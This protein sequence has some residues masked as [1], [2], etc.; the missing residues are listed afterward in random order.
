MSNEH[1]WDR[2]VSLVDKMGREVP[3]AMQQLWLGGRILPVGASLV[4]RHVFQIESNKPAEV[5]YAFMLPRDAAMRRFTV[6]GKNFS[7]TS[8]LKKTKEAVQSYEAGI[9]KGNLS[10]LV[11]QYR[12]G[13]VNLS[14]GNLRPRETVTV[15]L[16]LVAGVET[17]DDGFR[18]RFPFTLAPSYHPRARGVESRPG[19]G[20]LVV[21]GEEFG[22]VMLPEWRFDSKNLHEIGFD[23]ELWSPSGVN[24]VASPSHSIRITTAP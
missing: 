13:V 24:E 5:V 3:L 23:L 17:R 11:R 6:T 9:Q 15:L 20:E 21:P 12:D 18:F 16:E 4:V 7:I 19:K 22:D 8:E 14:L 1:G 10:A 2:L